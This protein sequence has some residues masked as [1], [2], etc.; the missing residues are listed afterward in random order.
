MTAPDFKEGEVWR[1]TNPNDDAWAE[2][3]ISIKDGV[4][5][6]TIARSYSRVVGMRVMETHFGPL[7]QTAYFEG[8]VWTR[9]TTVERQHPFYPLSSS[10]R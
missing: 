2:H 8:N 7:N 3:R 5:V 4:P 9:I 10:S 6:S 1:C